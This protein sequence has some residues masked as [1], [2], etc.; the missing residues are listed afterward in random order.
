MKID[1]TLSTDEHKPKIFNKFDFKLQSENI[2]Y[3]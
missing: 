3:S 2:T 1:K